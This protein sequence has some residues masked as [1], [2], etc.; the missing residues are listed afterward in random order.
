MPPTPIRQDPPYSAR[1]LNS[2]MDSSPSSPQQ[3]FQTVIPGTLL[4]PRA[5]DQVVHRQPKLG[6]Q[7]NLVQTFSDDLCVTET[8]KHYEYY[9]GWRVTLTLLLPQSMVTQQQQQQ[10]GAGG[11]P[12]V[13]SQLAG[14]LSSLQQL[15]QSR[16]AAVESGAGNRNYPQPNRVQAQPRGNANSFI[17]SSGQSS[18]T[19]GWRINMHACMKLKR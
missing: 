11:R 17:T 3:Q 18:W 10:P 6:H 13:L 4:T 15:T 14:L 12:Q 5:Q 7:L 2:G 1:Q 19:Q 8:S 9:D 16:M